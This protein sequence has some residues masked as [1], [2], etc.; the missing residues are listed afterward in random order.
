MDDEDDGELLAFDEDDEEPDEPERRGERRILRRL[1][2]ASPFVLLFLVLGIAVL[3]VGWN[4]VVSSPRF[5][6]SCHAMEPSVASAERSVHADVPCLACHTRPGILGSLRYLPTL[7]HEGLAVATDSSA[8]GV[9]E[10]RS[11]ELCHANVTSPISGEASGRE[12]PG[13]ASNCSTCHGDVAHPRSE[14]QDIV[15]RRPLELPHP[16]DWTQTHGVEVAESP[17]TC[18]TC[19]QQRF[20]EACHFRST[21]P[22][23]KDWISKHGPAQMQEGPNACTLCHAPTFCAG[24]H[25]TKIP[26]DPD[27]LG[28]HFR[29][30]QD[31]S[32]S[33]C[34]IC[35]ATT[36]C[37]I[38][39]AQHGVHIEQ[40]MYD[41]PYRRGA[42]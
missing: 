10:A 26:H 28:E 35:H 4:R 23:P 7:A 25:G 14:G 24:C 27:W 18:A 39:H 36:D 34:Y 42:G 9:L 30:L 22:H 6:A 1:L 19:H 21:F 32:T 13:P 38:C 2:P 3:L 33:P 31:K 29:E 40:E 15:E 12:H 5:C 16:S 41:D 17:A 20:C 11:C 37:T 8:D